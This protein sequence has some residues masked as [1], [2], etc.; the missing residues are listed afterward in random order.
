MSIERKLQAIRN[1]LK[2]AAQDVTLVCVTKGQPIENLHALLHAG[3]QHFG[4][5][6]LQDALPKMEALNSDDI[7]WHFLGRIQRNK[8]R[9]IAEHFH[10]VDSV[11][12]VHMAKRLSDQRPPHL[13]L[14]NICLQI[15]IDNDPNKA[16]ISPD[17]AL[18]LAPTVASLP[19]L[20]LRG[21]MTILQKSGSSVQ[22]QQS[23]KK[24]RELFD[25][26]NEQGL[27]LDTLS[28]GMSHDYP[29]ALVSGATT[30]RIGRALFETNEV[31]CHASA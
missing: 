30:V 1:E 25:A 3:E 28:M 9:K 26:F 29:E 7:Q 5:N 12:S 6:R 15:N 11:E 2:N 10:W 8:T 14:L 23:F 27:Q 17:E 18:S 19:N 16:G 20:K 4:E 13:P 24:M 21:L 22:S 31:S